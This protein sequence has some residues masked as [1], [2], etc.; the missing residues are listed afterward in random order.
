MNRKMSRNELGK[1][2]GYM[3]LMIT[4]V[5]ALMIL[6]VIFN[7]QTGLHR[8]S[9][10]GDYALFGLLWSYFL[11]TPIAASLA[12]LLG[13]RKTLAIRINYPIMILWFVIIVWTG[14]ITFL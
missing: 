12:I 2:L 13:D 3:N 7:E 10:M 11:I 9:G 4:L 14:T 1:I 5:S 8:S 6:L